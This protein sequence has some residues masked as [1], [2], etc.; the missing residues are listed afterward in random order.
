MT[1]QKQLFSNLLNNLLHKINCFIEVIFI[2]QLTKKC[3]KSNFQ[4][5]KYRFLKNVARFVRKYFMSPFQTCWDTLQILP[6][7]RRMT[8]AL[9]HRCSARL[10]FKTVQKSDERNFALLT[11]KRRPRSS[12]KEKKFITE[13]RCPVCIV[14]D[15]FWGG[16]NF[17]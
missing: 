2:L 12:Y 9:F 8:P 14:S 11:L 1:S 15:R 7:G 10:F 13:G 5:Q 4:A 6:R 16:K 3:S 17:L